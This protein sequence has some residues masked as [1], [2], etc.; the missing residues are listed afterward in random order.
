MNH[1]CNISI[2]DV[3]HSER[4]MTLNLTAFSFLKIYIYV[5]NPE[6]VLL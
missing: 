4:E 6:A 1:D 2:V 3:W 5:N